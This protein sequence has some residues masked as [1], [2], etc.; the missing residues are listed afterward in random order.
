MPLDSLPTFSVENDL[1]IGYVSLLDHSLR[2][3]SLHP[4]IGEISLK[5]EMTSVASTMMSEEEKAEMENSMNGGSSPESGGASTPLVAHPTA[6][7]RPTS[8]PNPTSPD[9]SIPTPGNLSP[10]EESSNATSTSIMASQGPDGHNKE[11]SSSS[12]PMPPKEKDPKKKPKM[13]PEQRAK[14]QELD[15]E[16]RR[17]MEERIAHLTKKLTEVLRPFVEAKHPGDKDDPET[18]VFENRIKREAEDLK[19]ESFGVEVRIFLS[20]AF[21]SLLTIAQLLHAIGTV[22]M[23]KASSF[24]KSRKFLGL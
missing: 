9:I 18:A 20:G 4:Q 16:R 21:I 11:A 6:S 2:H 8:P 24:M 22:Y 19:L 12:K 10:N 14:L 23:M 13:T 3:I 15:K 17:A 1:E 7:P 5:K